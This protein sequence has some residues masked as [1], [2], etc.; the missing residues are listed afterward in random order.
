MQI[1]DAGCR[2]VELNIDSF[3]PVSGLREIQFFLF[4][5]FVFDLIMNNLLRVE[6]MRWKEDHNPITCSLGNRNL[7]SAKW[8]KWKGEIIENA[9]GVPPGATP[10]SKYIESA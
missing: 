2:T 9:R 10:T 3:S 1:F 4:C 8:R 5:F 6:M 7:S